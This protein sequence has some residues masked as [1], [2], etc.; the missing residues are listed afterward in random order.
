MKQNTSVSSLGTTLLTHGL[1]R[2]QESGGMLNLITS[3]PDSLF[4]SH[5]LQQVSNS[6]V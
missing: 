2:S 4:M 5:W 1:I 6:N 3:Q